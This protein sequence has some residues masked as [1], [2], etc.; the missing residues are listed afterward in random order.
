MNWPAKATTMIPPTLELDGQVLV[1]GRASGLAIALPPLS[2][3]GGYDA[4]NGMIIDKTHA[5]Y[6][7]SLKDRILV[8]PRARGSSSSSSVLAEALRNRTG[9]SGIVL[10]ERDLILAI[11]VI[12]ANELYALNVPVVSV[13]EDVFA[14]IASVTATLEI[15]AG[16]TSRPARIYV[17]DSERDGNRKP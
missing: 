16:D 7:Q 1:P 14:Q 12:A 4:E 10:A 15:D 17:T 5:G 11:G 13:G 9:P 2:F 8:M 3:W 6:G